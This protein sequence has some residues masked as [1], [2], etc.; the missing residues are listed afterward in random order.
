MV[1]DRIVSCPPSGR[2]QG[3]DGQ[4]H[5]GGHL[6]FTRGAIQDHDGR[7]LSG[8]GL[9]VGRYLR[10]IGIGIVALDRPA[11]GFAALGGDFDWQ[12]EE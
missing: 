1:H 12:F 8:K 9:V 11:S 4:T 3:S 10:Q 6:I 7:I 5:R 2:E